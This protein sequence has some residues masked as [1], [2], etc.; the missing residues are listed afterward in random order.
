MMG[1]AER[2]QVE[3]GGAPASSAGHL[4]RK[5]YV[6]L[7]RSTKRCAY[8]TC[9]LYRQDLTSEVHQL[10]G[11]DRPA[12]LLTRNVRKV[13]TV[14]YRLEFGTRYTKT[15]CFVFCFVYIDTNTI[16]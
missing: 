11:A 9:T 14:L 6:L 5:Y 2:R 16:Q 13:C 7:L 10:T 12:H 8:S 3:A 1:A 4:C 15:S